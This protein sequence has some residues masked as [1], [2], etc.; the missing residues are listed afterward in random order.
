MAKVHS[1][2]VHEMLKLIH[3]IEA[4]FLLNADSVNRDKSRY[5]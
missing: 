5:I 2:F 3:M 4:Y 1:Y